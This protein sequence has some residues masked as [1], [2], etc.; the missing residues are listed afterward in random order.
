[1]K[2]NRFAININLR[3]NGYRGNN[4]SN[5]IL[6]DNMQKHFAMMKKLSDV[7]PGKGKVIA[8]WGRRNRKKSDYKLIK[9]ISS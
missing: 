8:S 6:A 2:D 7:H 5:E 3:D 1:V 9:V 4:G